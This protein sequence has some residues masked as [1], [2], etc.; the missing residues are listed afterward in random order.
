MKKETEDKFLPDDEDTERKAPKGPWEDWPDD[1]AIP[2]FRH[3]MSES[4][5]F[6]REMLQMMFP[7]EDI[8]DEDFDPGMDFDD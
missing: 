1:D 2:D 7:N 8:D 3:R 4:E 6:N 5:R